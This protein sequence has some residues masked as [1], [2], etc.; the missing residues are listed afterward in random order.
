VP[1]NTPERTDDVFYLPIR[2]LQL[3]FGIPT[4]KSR[5]NLPSRPIIVN[6]AMVGNK[7]GRTPLPSGCQYGH[8]GQGNFVGIWYTTTMI[9][10][11][12]SHFFMLAE[13]VF[14]VPV[15]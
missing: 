8:N 1:D 12:M 9:R 3:V 13:P 5:R 6:S 2:T 4:K 7:P 15:L 11:G 14:P 10:A